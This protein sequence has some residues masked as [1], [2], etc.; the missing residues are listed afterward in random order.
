M[1]TLVE[2]L[3]QEALDH[4]VPISQLLRRVKLIAAKLGLAAPAEWVDHELNGYDG[5]VP[6]YRRIRGQPQAHN[7]FHGW[8][9]I[10][11]HAEFVEAISAQWVGQ[12]VASLE[13]LLQGKGTLYFPFSPHQV[14]LINR[15]ADVQLAKMGLRVDRSSIVGILDA[16][17]SKVLD[18]AIELER[19]GILGTEVGFTREETRKAQAV[20]IHIANFHGNL[21]TGDAS[22]VNA[23]MNLGS[24]DNSTNV[25]NEPAIFSQLLEAVTQIKD[26]DDR[27]EVV[28]AVEEMRRQ[29]GKS[30]F[31]KAYAA[32]M[33]TASDHMT[34]VAP[35]LPALTSLLGG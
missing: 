20:S 3:Q 23:R 30:G 15:G 5:E 10:H 24:T 33:S 1:A 6:Q 25:A 7:P 12:S 26:P 22:G 2:Q 32:F 8:I 14:E 31:V 27:R 35:F 17:R 11:G 16:V 13:S 28:A 21:A 18:W 19:Q 34:V 4:K 9:P 29:Q